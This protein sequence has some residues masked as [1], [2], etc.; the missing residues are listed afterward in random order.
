MHLVAPRVI[1]N[2]KPTHSEIKVGI[3]SL[4]H[5]GPL[6]GSASFELPEALRI[7][8]SYLHPSPPRKNCP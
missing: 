1:R 5:Y 4:I 7:S 6:D 8:L 2:T 3:E